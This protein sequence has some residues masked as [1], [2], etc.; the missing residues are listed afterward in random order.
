MKPKKEFLILAVVIVAA[1]AYLGLKKTDR[2]HF[3]LPDL[4]KVSG[5]TLTRLEITN[6][7]KAFILEKKDG[8]WR[9]APQGWPAD[10]AKVKGVVDIIAGLK[11][12]ALVSETRSYA[13]YE[14]DEASRIS[15]KAWRGEKLARAFDIGKSAATHQHTHVH[16]ADDAN[17]YHARENFRNRF[18][19]S[20]SDFRDL[21]V[22]DFAADDI[23]TAQLEAGGKKA[24][25]ARQAVKGETADSKDEP[26]KTEWRLADGQPAD[27]A[28][29]T[30]L[31]GSIS[32]LNCEAFIIGQ[33]PEDFKNP[34]YTIVLTGKKTHRLE[35]FSPTGK[36]AE[37]FPAISSDTPY[38]FTLS[39]NQVDG[40]KD[41][42]EKIIQPE[43]PADLEK[44]ATPP[45]T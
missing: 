23:Q 16:L 35:I 34:I 20:A 37:N 14:L 6:K 29:I 24:D 11:V 15:V 22:M 3:D 13:R 28:G 39:K 36:D 10:E 26:A 4:P 33:S 2:T 21:S 19:R 40:F 17:V 12:T 7:G 27:P 9:I 38:P 41:N 44:G 42:I 1:V 30:G 5:K 32:R 31:V 43:K 25:L 45:S 18:D 8:Q